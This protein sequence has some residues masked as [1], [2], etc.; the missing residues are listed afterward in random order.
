MLLPECDMVCCVYEEAVGSL[1]V[2]GLDVVGRVG[3]Q[4][5][6]ARVVCLRKSGVKVDFVKAVCVFGPCGSH[7]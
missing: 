2:R 3:L 4:E 7:G 5:V 1:S 6:E